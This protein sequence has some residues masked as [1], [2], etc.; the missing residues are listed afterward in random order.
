MK[1]FLTVLLILP[2]FC[3]GQKIIVNYE[4]IKGGYKV[5]VDNCEYAP[6]TVKIDF[7]VQN[8]KPATYVNFIVLPPQSKK[9]QVNVL[10]AVDLN[11]P[12]QVAYNI[13]AYYGDHTIVNVPEYNYQLP[14]KSNEEYM[15]GQ[16]YNGTFS[17]RNENAID[18]T[19]PPGTD[20]T[21][22]REGVV[23][24]VEAS[25]T[26]TCPEQECS[27]YNNY[28]CIYQPDGTFAEYHHLSVNGARVKVGDKV[29]EGQVIGYSGN[30]GRS[31]APHLHF[32]VYVQR[33]TFRETIKTKFRVG[34]GDTTI[35]LTEGI[36]YRKEYE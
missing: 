1:Y 15:V 4:K 19:C 11:M 30:T 17:H 16:G 28:I 7:K 24:R 3:S 20:V 29:S 5:F 10:K 21:A 14:F 31:S 27:R 26:I 12:Y 22:A 32:M 13:L 35:Y 34:K 36:A 9:I 6:V 8:L 2:L 33:K 23:V 18:F 25:N